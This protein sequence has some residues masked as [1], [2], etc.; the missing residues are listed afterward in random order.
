MQF[1]WIGNAENFPGEIAVKRADLRN[2]SA[3]WQM[4]QENDSGRQHDAISKVIIPKLGRWSYQIPP[5]SGLVGNF[6]QLDVLAKFPRH[7]GTERS[8]DPK[9][10][11][12]K[13]G[14][15]LLAIL[16]RLAHKSLIVTGCA[17]ALMIGSSDWYEP[18]SIRSIL[19]LRRSQQELP[20]IPK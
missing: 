18:V 16:R 7:P 5:P 6:F 20:R 9:P 13:L 17:D 10:L 8:H 15:P 14:E 2:G 12:T 11:G 1:L 4:F 19:L 3:M